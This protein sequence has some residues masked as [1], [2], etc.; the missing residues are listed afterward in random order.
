[1]GGYRK[2]WRII[3]ILRALAVAVAWLGL[4]LPAAAAT[5]Q[6][7]AARVGDYKSG[8]RLVV[9][10]SA[11]LKV[12][13]F[14]LANPY[15][16]VIDLPEVDWR[17]SGDTPL[18]SHGLITGLRFGRFTP[19]TSR[20]VLDLGKPAKVAESFVLAPSAGGGPY[21][22][23]VDLEPI[24]AA[25]FAR[26]TNVAHPVGKA[27]AS[28]ER[29][30]AKS[31]PKAVKRIIVI[32]PGHGGVDPGTIGRA[33]TQEKSVTLAVSVELKRQLEATGRYT[34]LL[35][36]QNDQFMALRD[37]TAFARNAN[38][39]L[40]L[41]IHADSISDADTRGGS[42]YTLSERASDVEAAALAAKENKA[43][44]I[45]GVDLSHENGDVANILIDLAQR[46]T[47]NHSAQFANI[48]IDELG[49]SI[50]LLR[51]THR[52]A[53][54]AVL[55][56]PD[57]P[58]ALFELGYLSNRTDETLLRKPAHRAKVAAAIVRAV[59]RYFK[60]VG[61]ITRS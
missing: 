54:F 60:Q 43:D 14:T 36:R 41:S 12:Q 37:R 10:V 52:F 13:V 1:M 22:L 61:P 38:A 56:A 32:D 51:N 50:V 44:V 18:D 2:M 29:S 30:A 27:T 28:Q 31:A 4:S 7:S 21:R 26:A 45:G 59:D 47:M 8:A 23:V 16:V 55:K 42:V 9:D 46:E 48:L 6:A 24:S 49:Q 15:R 19:T 57:V 5:P 11:D 34:V 33:G 53:G 39:D 17:V 3:A 40:F 35:T 58:A 20:I 25:E